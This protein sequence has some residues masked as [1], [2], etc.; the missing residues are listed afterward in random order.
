MVQDLVINPAQIQGFEILFSLDP[1]GKVLLRHVEEA[2][3]GSHLRP[4]VVGS[5]VQR[6]RIIFRAENAGCRIESFSSS[7]VAMAEP[8]QD[9]EP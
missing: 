4:C 1:A 8:V 9:G 3:E 7:L 5:I 6:D 2:N